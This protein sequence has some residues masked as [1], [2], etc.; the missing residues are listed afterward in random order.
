MRVAY[1]K[2]QY[3]SVFL[4]ALLLSLTILETTKPS[5]TV[6]P[7][8][9]EWCAGSK[10]SWAVGVAVPEGGETSQGKVD[11]GRS[12]NLTVIFTL[13]SIN[14]TEATIYVIVSAINSEGNVMQ[15]AAG[16]EPG[17]NVWRS[18]AMYITGVRELNTDYYPI[19]LWGPPLFRPSEN[20]SISLYSQKDEN[21]MSWI[22]RFRNLSTGQENLAKIL[23]GGDGYFMVG[24]QEVVTLE[25]YTWSEDVFSKMRELRVHGIFLDGCKVIRGLYGV[26]GLAFDVDTL[27]I[28]GGGAPPPPFIRLEIEDNGGAKWVY[29]PI[30]WAETGHASAFYLVIFAV[31]ILIVSIVYV[32]LRVE[33]GFMSR[34]EVGK[35]AAIVKSTPMAAVLDKIRAGIRRG[36]RRGRTCSAGRERMVSA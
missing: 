33:S 36:W 13:P 21:G 6:A 10:R 19:L 32:A 34:H 26:S 29:S 24:D 1:E 16:L 27:F 2:V 31:A 11:W 5:D 20:A 15:A 35:E 3:F 23:E 7:S 25:A 18:Y 9:C 17:D 8:S 28:V 14:S 12:K 4:L 22:A 30:S